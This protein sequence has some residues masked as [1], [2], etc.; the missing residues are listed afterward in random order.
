MHFIRILLSRITT[1]VSRVTNVLKTWKKH[2]WRSATFV[3]LL[4]LLFCSSYISDNTTKI[5]E[6]TNKTS[7]TY[8]LLSLER[9]Q[10]GSTWLQ[11]NI[12]TG[13]KQLTWN[14]LSENKHISIL[15]YH[16]ITKALVF[17]MRTFHL[18]LINQT[19][20]KKVKYFRCPP[21]NQVMSLRKYNPLKSRLYVFLAYSSPTYKYWIWKP[22][23]PLR[24]DSWKYEFDS[25][26]IQV[27]FR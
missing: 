17:F 26:R 23:I 2:P 21:V 13:Y 15:H 20:P 18:E 3:L 9:Q 25:S 19:I 11:K 7:K 4:L 6:N 10:P 24:K 22:F 1:N 8:F 5:Q 14:V 27:D 12:F 16:V